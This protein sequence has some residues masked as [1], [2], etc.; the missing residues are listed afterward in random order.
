M[1]NAGKPLIVIGCPLAR[2]AVPL[3]YIVLQLF[4]DGEVAA[5]MPHGVRG[6]GAL[7]VHGIRHR[8]RVGHIPDQ[9]MGVQGDL[10][11]EYLSLTRG[12]GAGH[13]VA[14]ARAPRTPR[15]TLSFK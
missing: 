14:G 11:R 5:R 13:I 3:G 4:P 6:L 10:P 7:I 12:G 2:V 9:Y 15:T 1:E 8:L